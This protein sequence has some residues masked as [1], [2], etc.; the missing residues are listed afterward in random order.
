MNHAYY[1][2]VRSQ[3]ERESSYRSRS[4]EGWW[5]G[6]PRRTGIV[7]Q[8]NYLKGCHCRVLSQCRVNPLRRGRKAISAM[9]REAV[10]TTKE[11]SPD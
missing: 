8:G 3:L 6:F 2:T 7:L 4:K 1:L 10:S 9:A 11:D 5:G